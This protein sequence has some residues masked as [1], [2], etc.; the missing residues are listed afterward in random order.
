MGSFQAGGP[1][2][3]SLGAPCSSSLWTL[4]ARGPPPAEPSKNFTRQPTRSPRRCTPLRPVAPPLW[5]LSSI[6]FPWDNPRELPSV[7]SKTQNLASL[8]RDQKKDSDT[9]Q[10]DSCYCIILLHGWWRVLSPWQVT[11][12]MEVVLENP[13]AQGSQIPVG[14]PSTLNAVSSEPNTS[15]PQSSSSFHFSHFCQCHH[16]YCHPS[17]ALEPFSTP[18]FPL[19]LHLTGTREPAPPTPRD[20][21]PGYTMGQPSHWSRLSSP[22]HWPHC[23]QWFDF[24]YVTSQ[25]QLPSCRILQL[26]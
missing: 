22:F 10:H 11:W 19:L 2:G 12:A 20:R 15:F 8:V 13:G 14:S 24:D 25:L 21:P 5:A 26:P 18:F 23:F 9:C 16:H 6:P 4:R 1:G 7:G 17:S 3:P